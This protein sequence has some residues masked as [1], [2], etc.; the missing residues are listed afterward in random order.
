MRCD[1][2][3]GNVGRR[4]ALNFDWNKIF[5]IVTAVL[6]LSGLI[7]GCIELYK[8]WTQNPNKQESMDSSDSEPND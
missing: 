8:H 7:G 4:W 1:D 6:A 5:W 2:C 3:Y